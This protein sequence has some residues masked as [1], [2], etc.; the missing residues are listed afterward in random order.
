MKEEERHADPRR[1]KKRELELTLIESWTVFCFW[2][3]H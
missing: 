1:D 2:F 3:Q